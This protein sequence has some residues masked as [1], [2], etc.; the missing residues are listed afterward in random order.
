MLEKSFQRRLE[1]FLNKENFF[2]RHQFGFRKG[3]STKDAILSLYSHILSNFEQ[4]NKSLCLFFDLKRAFDVISIELMLTSFYEFGIRGLAY[5]WIESYLTGR[6]QKV[7]LK[8]GDL[9]VTSKSKPVTNGVPQG[10]ILGPLLFIMFFDSI[11]QEFPYHYVAAFADDAV[12][13]SS[14]SDLGILSQMSTSAVNR[15]VNFCKKNSLILNGSKTEMILFSLTDLNKSLLVKMHNKSIEQSNV[16]KYLGVFLDEHLTWS[17][18]VDAVIK[19]LS[20]YSYVIW[21]ISRKVDIKLV[22]LYYYGYVQSCLSYAIMCWG[23]CSRANEVFVAQKKIIRIMLFKP[24][25]FSCRNLFSELNVLTFPC[26]FIFHSVLHIKSNLSQYSLT[27]VTGYDLRMNLN[28]SLPKHKLAKVANSP[29]VLPIKLYNKLPT[30]VKKIQKINKFR[31]LLMTNLVKNSFYS[32]NEY[33]NCNVLG[34]L[35]N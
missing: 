14:N 16:T 24:Y 1:S 6:E 25:N 15:M 34:L 32:I 22:L 2:S 5:S 8:K 18:Q 10:S 19:K 3:L 4:N 20:I 28:I 21:Q 9:S 11:M 35:P 30:E 12:V 29:L 7:K 26:L 27:G 31:H 23:N 33:L 13:T 17:D